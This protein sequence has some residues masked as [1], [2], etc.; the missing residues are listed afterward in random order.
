MMGKQVG[1]GTSVPSKEHNGV[2][3]STSSSHHENGTEVPTPK[4]KSGAA[5]LVADKSTTKV[6]PQATNR[7]KSG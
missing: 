1:A 3:V 7:L 6:V 5:T 2:E 4:D